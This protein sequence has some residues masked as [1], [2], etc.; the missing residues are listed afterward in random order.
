VTE[1]GK[2]KGGKGEKGREKER[3]KKEEQVLPFTRFGSKDHP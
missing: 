1:K 2:E 3:G